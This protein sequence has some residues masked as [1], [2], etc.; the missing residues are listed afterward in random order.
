MMLMSDGCY[1]KLEITVMRNL[2][3]IAV[4]V[5]PVK[6]VFSDVFFIR[7]VSMGY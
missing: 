6:E 4:A 7:H 5:Y 2:G 1:V 3:M